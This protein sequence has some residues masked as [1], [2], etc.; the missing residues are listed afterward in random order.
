MCVAFAKQEVAGMTADCVIC[1]FLSACVA[2]I[3]GSHHRR[4]M[5]GDDDKLT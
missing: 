2:Y 1:F 5:R 3:G 4:L